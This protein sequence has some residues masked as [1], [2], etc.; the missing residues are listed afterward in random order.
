M[1]W[2]GKRGRGRWRHDEDRYGPGA[3]PRPE[4]GAPHPRGPEDGR[5]D[6][7]SA[8]EQPVD[9]C[10]DEYRQA[11]EEHRNAWEEHRRAW[12]EHRR[13]LSEQQ[14]AWKE[15]KRDQCSPWGGH[16][17]DAEDLARWLRDE[18]EA[19]ETTQDG[20]WVHTPDEAS[21]HG[22]EGGD[23]RLG[24][25]GHPRWNWGRDGHPPRWNHQRER[26]KRH[27]W[28]MGR[29]GH[30]VRA[31]L[32][33]RLFLWFGLTILMTGVVTASVFNLVGGTTWKQ[34]MARLRNFAGHRFE[35]VWNEPA[36]RDALARS[37]AAD[38]D[39]DV[40]LQDASGKVLVL[41][42]GPCKHSEL[43]IPVTRGSLELGQVRFCY[44]SNRAKD[45]LRM[46]VPLLAAG[47]VF[48]IAA[49]KMARRLA[50]PVDA[51][52]RATEALGAGKLKS[53]AEVVPHATGEFTVL[54][55]AFNDMAS[56]IEKQVAD[57]RELLAAVSHELRTPLARLR[58]LTELLRDGGGNPKTLDQVDREVVEL[59]ALVGELLASSRLDFGQLTPR[60]LDARTLATQ[61]LE[62]AGLAASLLDT[63]LPDTGLVGDATLLGRALI[64]LLDNARK[65]GGG[66][67]ALR[68][69]Q[70]GEHLS[71]CVDDRGP[72]LQAGEEERIFKPFYRKD[73]GVEAR[74]AGSLG[75][76]LALVQRIAQAHGGEVF[77]QNREGGGARVGFTVKK[78]GPPASVD[79]P[80]A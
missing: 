9:P 19:R 35:E 73:R 63:S 50:K 57:Q 46:I 30:F 42:G 38:L 27:Y 49:G 52:V 3:P 62:R 65:H 47:L 72:G 39:V 16:F 37:V 18:R 28:R 11:W 61:A 67:E 77:A 29:L 48:W 14:R 7:A 64:N 26:L 10:D 55:V 36:R 60:A 45:P 40:E 33:R 1:G 75:L 41:E 12:E 51:L 15:W 8:R 43:T 56:R 58:V 53:R 4:D 78:E 13:A 54:A 25:P 69:E 71:F 21:R 79:R 34:E 66:A 6:S 44:G 32:H 68:I 2:R 17:G 76:G 70:Q 31:R 23:P 80:A 74:E 22:G 24:R 5:A 20:Q 59:D